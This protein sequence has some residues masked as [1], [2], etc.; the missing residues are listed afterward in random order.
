MF[1][2]L[3][4]IARIMYGDDAVDE[5]NRKPPKRKGVRKRNR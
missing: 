1:F 4:W 3:N 5:V 2:F